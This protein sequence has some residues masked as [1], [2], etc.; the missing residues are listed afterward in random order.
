MALKEFFQQYFID[1]IIFNTG[2]NPVNST[3]YGIILIMAF[4]LTYKLLQKMKIKIDKKFFFAIIPFVFLGGVLRSLED[5]WEAR[6][7]ISEGILKNLVI[8][9]ANGVT[10]NLLLVTPIMYFTIFFIALFSLIF[11]IAVEKIANRNKKNIPYYYT[12][13]FIGIV[14]SLYFFFQLSF[15]DYLAMGMILGIFS[16]WVILFLGLRE[17]GRRKNKKLFEFLSLENTMIIL[18]HMLDAS[19]TFVALSY[20]GYFEQHFLPRFFM[21]ILGPSAFFALKLPIILLALYYVDK[22]M[23]DDGKRTF[24]KIVILILGLAPGLRDML[25]L[26]MLV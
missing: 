5:L 4:I 23:E 14:L 2:Y 7:I 19:S 18:A 15:A 8:V 3:V 20:Y 21:D 24:L 12:W 13:G 9:D 16:L 17:Y 6:G 26:G 25:R 1:P 22:E 10:R 11:S